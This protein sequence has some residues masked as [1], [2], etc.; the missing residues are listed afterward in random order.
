MVYLFTIIVPR[1]QKVTTLE[2]KLKCSWNDIPLLTSSLLRLKFLTSL[3]SSWV[4][5]KVAEVKVGLLLAVKPNS[6]VCK[7]K[8]MKESK[9]LPPDDVIVSS[10]FHFPSAQAAFLSFLT[11][12]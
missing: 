8:E 3:N 5:K 7:P 1:P 2:Q 9:P 12:P 11:P 6:K 10:L 4:P